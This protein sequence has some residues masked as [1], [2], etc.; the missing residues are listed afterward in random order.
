MTT[1]AVP[2][3]EV[4]ASRHDAGVVFLHVPKGRLFGSNRTGGD[5]WERLAQSMSLSA[6]AEDI[7]ARYH[8]SRE[9][10]WSDTVRFVA[11]LEREQLVERRRA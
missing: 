2:T 7:S 1:F 5:I 11:A 3:D 8:V 6:I 4:V 10:A 9:T